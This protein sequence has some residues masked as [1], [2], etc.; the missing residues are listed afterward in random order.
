MPVM[1]LLLCGGRKLI[2]PNYPSLA[3]HPQTLVIQLSPLSAFLLIHLLSPEHCRASFLKLQSAPV[4]KPPPT[5]VSKRPCP[6]LLFLWW[7][8][9]SILFK[10]VLHFLCWGVWGYFVFA[11]CLFPIDKM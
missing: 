9:A 8:L 4:P 11:Y 2:P 10:H 3:L 1:M 5:P 7:S 6:C